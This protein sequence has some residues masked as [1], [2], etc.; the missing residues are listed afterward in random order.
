LLLAE[1]KRVK[2]PKATVARFEEVTCQPSTPH[3]DHMHVR[4][5][6]TPE[7]MKTGCEDS[8]PLYPWRVSALQSYGLEPV[9]ASNKRSREE[10]E[11]AAARTTTPAEAKKKAGPMHKDVVAFLKQREAWLKQPHPGRPYCK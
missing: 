10:R 5:F 6:C 2:A 3:D 4:F 1:A 7:D 9:I 8:T 11:A